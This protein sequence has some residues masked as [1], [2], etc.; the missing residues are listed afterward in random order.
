MKRPDYKQGTILITALL[1]ASLTLQAQEAKKEFH[2]EYAASAKTTLEI[3]NKYGDVVIESWDKDQ[4]IIDVKVSVDMPNRE[5]AEKFLSYIEIQFSESDNY[6]SAKTVIDDKFNFTGWGDNKKFSID[7]NIKMP[8]A[9]ALTLSNRYGNTE[10]DELTGLVSLDIKYGNLTADKMSRGNVKPLNSI[11]IAYGNGAIEQ[12]GWLDITARYVGTFEITKSQAILLDSKYSK[13][14]IGETSSIVGESKYDNL[15]ISRINNLVLD[16]GYTETNIGTLS[17]K[18]SYKGSYGSFA[19]DQIPAGFES[20]ETE[21]RYMGVKLGIE[22]SAEYRLNAKVSYGGL[23]YN[24][25]SFKNEKRIIENNSNEV[26]GVFGKS[27][28]P[29]ATV[30]VQASY[31]TVRLN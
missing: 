3:S 7:Y 25:D 14:S 1:L 13:F 2:K 20:L 27:D 28:N 17:K 5:K 21:T 11:N 19:I 30:N 24:E 26:S 9:T 8:S 15:K 16:N 4:I 22:E 6:I 12:A 18:L 23:K 10:F 29:K 31:G